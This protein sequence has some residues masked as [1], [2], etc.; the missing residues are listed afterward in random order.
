MFLKWIVKIMLI[1][2]KNIIG[3]LTFIKIIKKFKIIN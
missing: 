1:Y 2:N 3:K